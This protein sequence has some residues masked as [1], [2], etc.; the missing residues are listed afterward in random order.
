MVWFSF[1]SAHGGPDHTPGCIGAGCLGVGAVVVIVVVVVFVFS[2]V[3]CVCARGFCLLF[4]VKLCVLGGVGWR[5]EEQSV[6][7]FV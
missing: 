6:C 7:A 5:H 2:V 1:P 3:I 4:F